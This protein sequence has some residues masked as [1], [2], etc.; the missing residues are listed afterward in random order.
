MK[1]TITKTHWSTYCRIKCVTRTCL[2]K[3]KL[4]NS[5]VCF[6]YSFSRWNYRSKAF[7][8]MDNNGDIFDTRNGQWYAQYNCLHLN[9]T[10][11]NEFISYSYLWYTLDWSTILQ[12]T[13]RSNNYPRLSSFCDEDTPVVQSTGRYMYIVFKSDT[14]INYRGFS[15]QYQLMEAGIHSTNCNSCV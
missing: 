3:Y 7:S 11:I 2:L 5:N 9:R 15:A 14:T 6:C 1:R 12:Q 10:K 8:F 4:P 13:G